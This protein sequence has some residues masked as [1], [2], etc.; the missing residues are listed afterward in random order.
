[1]DRELLE[2][3]M[4]RTKTGAEI[5]G[6]ELTAKAGIASGTISNVLT[7]TRTRLQVSTVAAICDVLG[8]ELLILGPI[9]DRLESAAERL[10]EL[11][12]A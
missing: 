5:S 3:L 8:V 7:G 1:V 4:K 6:R 11:T 2:R 9:V 10:S 12:A